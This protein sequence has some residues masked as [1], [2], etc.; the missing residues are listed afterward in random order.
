MWVILKF[1]NKYLELF[2]K[3]LKDKLGDEISIYKPKFLVQK[4]KNNKIIK[5]E[6]SLLGDY[7]FCFHKDFTDNQSLNKFKFIR[8][9]KYFLTGFVESQDE[10]VKFIKKCRNS[11]NE[12]GYLSYEFYDLN[13]NS[14]YQFSNGPFSNL[15]F[16]LLNFQKNKIK[17]LIGNLK[18]TI[19][20]KEF[21]F[22]PV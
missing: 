18:T 7:L 4:Y 12:E 17:I 19:R 22:K 15:V 21:L 11:E 20:K 16:K 9:L 13:I 2:K 1:D 14:Q 6:M 8:G 10:I 5:Q 3:D